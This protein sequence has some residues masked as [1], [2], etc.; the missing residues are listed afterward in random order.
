MRRLVSATA[1]M[2]CAGLLGGCGILIGSV[3]PITGKSDAYSFTAPS[4]KDSEWKALPSD[5]QNADGEALEPAVDVSDRS[6]QHH[7]SGAIVSINSACRPSYGYASE[8]LRK[9]TDL[10]LL[11]FMDLKD[12][13]EQ[14]L[15]LQGLDAL[16]TT[17]QGKVEGRTV[18]I[19]TVVTRRIECLYDLM[20]VAKPAIFGEQLDDFTKF[21]QSL[22]F[23]D[24][25]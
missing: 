6:W 4:K 14:T 20:Y 15:A 7:R 25:G 21:V 12:R 8:P 5:T 17:V 1:A 18:K 22:K 2:I 9:Y 16:Q 24:A 11:G 10:L 19:R 3:K 13:E 23:D